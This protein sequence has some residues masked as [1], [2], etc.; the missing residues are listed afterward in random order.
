M[1]PAGAALRLAVM[2]LIFLTA[3][4]VQWAALRLGGK[5]PGRLPIVV[6][7][8]FLRLFGV[9]VEQRGHPPA[10]RPA[11][12]LA[13]HVSWLDIPVLGSLAP[14]S[15]VAKA[16]VASWPLFGSFARLQR[17]VFVDRQRRSATAEVN[18]VVAHRL[19]GGDMMVLFPEGTTGDGLRMLP[20]RSSLVGAA[21]A[22]LGEPGTTTI[23]LQ[24]LAIAY[25]RRNGLPVTRRERPSIAWYGDMALSPHLAA[26]LREGALDVVVAWGEPIAF[27]A[28]SD[29][30]R[31]TVA[32][33]AAVRAAMAEIRRPP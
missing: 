5:L 12:V 4:P 10:A 17:S 33:E 20:F 6:H 13:N 3:A 29:R 2:A 14:L 25:T 18:A 19:A 7:R 30:K 22:V 1:I 15:F 23:L 32:A 27:A 8:I 24:P 16:E 11:L 31:A 28:T 21:R 26:F 9:R